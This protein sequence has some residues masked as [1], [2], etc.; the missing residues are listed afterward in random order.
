MS[1]AHDTTAPNEGLRLYAT[2][3]LAGTGLSASSFY[4]ML[5]SESEAGAAATAA[6][7]GWDVARRAHRSAN[8]EDAQR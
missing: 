3:I 1:A 2:H 4:E 8:A 6:Q 7:H 5:D